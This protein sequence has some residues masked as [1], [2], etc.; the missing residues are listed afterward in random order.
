MTNTEQ[1]KLTTLIGTGKFMSDNASAYTGVQI[2]IDA[3][4]AFDTSVADTKD[5]AAK[6][7]VDNSGFSE[8]KLNKKITMIQEAAAICGY[9]KQDWDVSQ[10][11]L[12]GQLHDNEADYQLSDADCGALAQEMF[13]VLNVNSTLLNAAHVSATDLTAFQVVIT[14]FTGAHGSSEAAHAAKP[15]ATLAFKKA[16]AVSMKKLKKLLKA[17]KKVRTSQVEFYKGLLLVAEIVTITIRH[18]HIHLTVKKQVDGSPIEGAVATF[19]DRTQTGTSDADGMIIIDGIRGGSL[20]M[21]LR[22]VGFVDLVVLVHVKAGRDNIL[23]A[24]MA[25][26]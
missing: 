13:N 16:M 22:K 26:I 14:A 8:D 4:T 15:E 21:T 11:T 24:E 20:T 7:T 25:A 2:I 17:C 19:A 9:A 23:V 10:P 3:K 18:T 5:K 12:A 6:A 1:A